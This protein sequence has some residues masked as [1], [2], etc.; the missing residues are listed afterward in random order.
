MNKIAKESLVNKGLAEINPEPFSGEA[1]LVIV[2]LTRSGTS[3]MSSLMHA[4]G[5]F[6]G[7]RIDNAVFED[8]EAADYVDKGDFSGMKSFVASRNANHKV[9]GFKRPNAYKSLPDLVRVLR[10][11]R[12]IV[13]FRDILAIGMRNHVS[14]QMDIIPALP[15]LVNEYGQLVKNISGLKCPMLLVSYE[16]FLQFP[17]ESIETTAAFCGV[18]LSDDLRANALETVRNGPETYLQSSRLRYVGHVDRIV[19][20][21]LRGWVMV[22]DQ[23]KIKAKVHLV[24]DGKVLDSTAANMRRADLVDAGIGDGHHGFELD[25][26]GSIQPDSVIEVRAG[27]AEFVLPNSGK[28]AASYGL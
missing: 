14:M 26:G 22:V 9:W 18:T 24:A 11:P 20:G 1:T 2:G 7:D 10:K 13:M 16:K 15:R 19:H 8:V 3:M 27:N 25:L 17:M 28:D 5:V 6:M 21:K 23:P 12:I 4:F